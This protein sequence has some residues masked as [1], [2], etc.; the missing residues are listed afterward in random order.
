[1]ARA[2][3]CDGGDGDDGNSGEAVD[4]HGDNGD[5]IDGHGD[6]GDAIDG[7]GDSGD[8]TDGSGAPRIIAFNDV[9]TAFDYP[10]RLG[11][12]AGAIRARTDDSTLL[13][14]AGDST[15]LGALAFTTDC[16]RGQ[17]TAFH[18]AVAPDV[19]VPGNHDFDHGPDWLTEFA[20]ATPGTWLAANAHHDGVFE[21]STVRQV[22]GEE[23]AVVGVAH[24]ETATFCA[25]AEAVR[26]TDPVAAVQRAFEAIGPVEHR[27]VLS[28]CGQRDREIAR[29]TDA[30]VVIGGHDHS[31]TIERVDGTL[32]CRTA[33]KGRELLGVTVRDT[34]EATFVDTATATPDAEVLR[35]YRGRLATAGL[36]DH[37]TTLSDLGATAT[38][39]LVARAYQTRADADA[40]LVFE[41][42]VREP[43]EGAVTTGDIVGTVPFGSDLVTVELAGDQLREL[44]GNTREPIDDTHG[45]GIWAGVDVDRKSIARGG[46]AKGEVV[47][48]DD[49]YRVGMMSYV[50]ESEVLPGI[51]RSHVVATHGPQHEHVLDYLRKNRG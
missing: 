5:A 24:P 30:D 34:P 45:R 16:G 12:L 6:S 35:A 4:G 37:V 43:L 31:R 26:F 41:A 23:V 13:L 14:D 28:H 17:A 50:P 19:H 40:G 33:G 29:N 47:D 15:A 38:A 11:R 39:E 8:A 32:V 18:D 48:P 1:M 51:D 9:E 42:S 3:G 25:A 2:G 44:L 21:G 46:T 7:H 27:V 22:A 49:D 20:A 10:D 36:D